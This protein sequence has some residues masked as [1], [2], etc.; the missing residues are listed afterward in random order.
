MIE[1]LGIDPALLMKNSDNDKKFETTISNSSLY[2]MVS[3]LQTSD[4]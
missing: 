3:C 1:L 2:V 4:I